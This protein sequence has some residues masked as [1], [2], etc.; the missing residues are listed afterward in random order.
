M[1]LL[2]RSSVRAARQIPSATARRNVHFENVVGKVRTGAH[3][4][5]VLTGEQTP[6]GGS[7]LA[8]ISDNLPL[9][10]QLQTLPFNV[11]HKVGMA[12]KVSTYF[13]VGFGLPFGAAAWHRECLAVI[14]YRVDESVAK[15]E[16]SASRT[17]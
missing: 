7:N 8:S 3:V 16:S 12:I 4:N 15:G 2:L 6:V 10:H 1:S 11:E 17:V 9:V 13:I 14:L 5:A